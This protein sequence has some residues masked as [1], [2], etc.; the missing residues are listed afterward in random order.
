LPEWRDFARLVV[1]TAEDEERCR[2]MGI[3]DLRR[4]YRSV[5]SSSGN[6][7]DFRRHR[8]DRG[9]PDERRPLFRD[10][11]RTGSLIMQSEPRQIRFIDSIHVSARD[12]ATI[13]F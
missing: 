10:G 13:R 2:A 3:T 6:A 11:T 5:D 8:G 4:V 1:R 12:D 7:S 9:C